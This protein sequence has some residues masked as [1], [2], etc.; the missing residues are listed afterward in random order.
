MKKF[1]VGRIKNSVKKPQAM[2]FHFES[3]VFSYAS[4]F[5]LLYSKAS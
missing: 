5:S 4:S 3:K 1:F 2:E